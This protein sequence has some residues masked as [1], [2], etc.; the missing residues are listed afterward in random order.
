MPNTLRGRV[1]AL[2][3]QL[4]DTR[5]RLTRLE[6][7]HI[8]VADRLSTNEVYAESIAADLAELTRATHPSNHGGES[9]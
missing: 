5:Q 4:V 9:R 6:G 2:E 7:N 3:Q 8:E 1:R